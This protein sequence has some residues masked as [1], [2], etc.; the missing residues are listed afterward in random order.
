MSGGD[1]M[2]ARA[3]LALALVLAACRGHAR[4]DADERAPSH[5][6]VGASAPVVG[7]EPARP[8]VDPPRPKPT[9]PPVV[10]TPP[11]AP[12]RVELL[13]IPSRTDV[14]V[15][16]LLL[17]PTTAPK[18]AVV[19]LAGGDGKLGLAADG[20]GPGAD[21]F[22]LRMRQPLV[23]AGLLVAIVDTPSDRPE[24]LED[25][26]STTAHAD[27]LAAVL[28]RLRREHDVPVW[29]M[30]TSRGAISAANAA[31]RL[32]TRG[33]DGL[34]LLSTI[35]AGRHETI[36][37]VP[38][39]A[40]TVPTLVVHHRGD[41]CKASP[42]GGTRTLLRKLGHAKRRELLWFGKPS[43]AAEPDPCDALT[44]HGFAGSEAEVLAGVL[45]FMRG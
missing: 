12:P 14:R 25:A 6:D 16:V 17:R 34:V 38:L 22:L 42:P 18:L 23:D 28:A 10:R 15:P 35:T 29:M 20:L 5:V 13:A 21:N 40:I 33:P 45:A 27:D 4:I 26:R 8:A 32:G 44:R 2:D 37:D 43:R 7:A 9:P 39:A 11:P 24:G 19:L 41:G 30:G 3:G 31:A 36:A 1:R